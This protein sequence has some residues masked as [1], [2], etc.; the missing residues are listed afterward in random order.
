MLTK[1]DL[2]SFYREGMPL[3]Q[4]HLHLYRELLKKEFPAAW[5]HL[6]EKTCAFPEMYCVKWMLTMFTYALPF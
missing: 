5:V 4:L 1:F 3:L 6:E 2:S